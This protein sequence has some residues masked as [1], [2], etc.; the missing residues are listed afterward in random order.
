[1]GEIEGRLNDTRSG[2]AELAEHRVDGV[3]SR[4]DLFPDLKVERNV[5]SGWI[6]TRSTESKTR[7]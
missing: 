3:E 1:M 5:V 2:L 7:H 4:V 6:Q